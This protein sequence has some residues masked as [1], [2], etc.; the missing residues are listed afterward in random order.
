MRLST[1][2]TLAELQVSQLAARRGVPN[3]IPP[4]LLP[5]ARELAQMLEGIRWA[6]TEDAG[7]DC[8]VIVSSGYRS[9]WLNEQVGG[10]QSSDHLRAQAA[11]IIAPAYGTPF[12]VARLIAR[13][14]DVLGVGQLIHEYGAWVHVS[15]RKPLAPVNRILTITRGQVL[16]GI[17][18][19]PSEA[20]A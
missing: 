16:A 11:D 8:P 5:A 7:R 17:Q 12:E 1:H 6:L 13:H 3:L 18:P 20:S 14:L 2:F 19:L 9:A 15:T 10:A 4:E